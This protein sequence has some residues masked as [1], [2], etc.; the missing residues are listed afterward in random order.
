MSRPDSEFLDGLMQLLIE[1]PRTQIDEDIVADI[2]KFMSEEHTR[3]EKYDFIQNIANEPLNMISDKVGVGRITPFVKQVCNLNAAFAP[4]IEPIEPI[5]SQCEPIPDGYI[6]K[7]GWDGKPMLV[8]EE[9]IF[10]AI[11]VQYLVEHQDKDIEEDVL[12]DIFTYMEDL[13][14]ANKFDVVDDFIKEF[15]ECEQEICFQYCLCLLTAACWANYKIKNKE[16]LIEKTKAQ[17]IKEIGEKDTMSC[18][19]GLT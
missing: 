17:G 10:S 18:L 5:M 2:K 3:D 7:Y 19:K 1:A 15:C 8:P 13:M 16:M 11:T 4:E 6:R 12:V 14:W 9:P